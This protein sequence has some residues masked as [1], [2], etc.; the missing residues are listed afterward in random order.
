MWLMEE[1]LKNL[2]L[3][4]IGSIDLLDRQDFCSKPFSS[5]DSPRILSNPHTGLIQRCFQLNSEAHVRCCKEFSD[6]HCTDW[7]VVLVM[8]ELWT[9]PADLA[10]PASQ[11]IWCFIE[12]TFGLLKHGAIPT[13]ITTLKRPSNAAQSLVFWLTK[14]RQLEQETI[15]EML[16]VS[17][18][19]VVQNGEL[20]I[21]T[22]NILAGFACQLAI[23]IATRTTAIWSGNCISIDCSGKSLANVFDLQSKV[24]DPAYVISFHCL[25]SAN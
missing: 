9:I 21:S 19:E 11:F 5:M 4:G 2:L 7:T 12:G 3:A 23:R 16:G 6:F 25:I 1:I 13:S 10:V 17:P 18:F 15:F 24:H 14:W 20:S 22:C 8:D